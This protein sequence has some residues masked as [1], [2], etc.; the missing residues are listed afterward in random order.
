M[1][2]EKIPGV[3]SPGFVKYMEMITTL[4]HKERPGNLISAVNSQGIGG[5]WLL[6]IPRSFL[7]LLSVLF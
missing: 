4:P 6:Q 3:Y 1:K 7:F 2:T 5:L